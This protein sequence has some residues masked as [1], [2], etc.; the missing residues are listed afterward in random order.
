MQGWRELLQ[1]AACFSRYRNS[2]D[3]RKIMTTRHIALAVMVGLAGSAGVPGISPAAAQTTDAPQPADPMQAPPGVRPEK[4]M[5]ESR[6]MYSTEERDQVREAVQEDTTLVKGAVKG[7][8]P[9]VR[10]D[11]DSPPVIVGRPLPPTLPARQA[12]ESLIEKLPSRPNHEVWIFGSNLA[13]VDKET[14][15]VTDIVQDI[16]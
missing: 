5:G 3:R 2:L 15:E 9:S 7:V 16:F 14:R 11:A 13:L 12:P 10:E 8:A 6:G 1:L 4:A